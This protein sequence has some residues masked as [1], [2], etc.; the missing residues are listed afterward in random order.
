MKNLFSI[1]LTS[2]IFSVDTDESEKKIKESVDSKQIVYVRQRFYSLQF[3]HSKRIKLYSSPDHHHHDRR[4]CI[5]PK[6]CVCVY[7]CECFQISHKKA[8][9]NMKSKI[10]SHRMIVHFSRSKTSQISVL[11]RKHTE[12]N[13]KTM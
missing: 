11:T 8:R 13:S 3:F 2:D 4:H 12:K 7:V 10:D 5:I 6:V 1:T 9:K